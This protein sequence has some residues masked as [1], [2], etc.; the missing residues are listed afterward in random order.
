MFLVAFYGF[1]RVGELTVKGANLKSLVHVQDLHFQFSNNVVTSATVVIKDFKHN[2][3]RRPFSVFLERA[4]GFAQW[5]IYNAISLQGVQPQVPCFALLTDLQLRLTSLRSSC[6]KP[7]IFV[8]LMQLN[9]NLTL[10]GSAPPLLQLKKAYRMLKFVTL[11]V[12]NP[13]HL[14]YT[15]VNLQEYLRIKLA[16]QSWAGAT[17]ISRFCLFFIYLFLFYFIF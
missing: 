9:T 6:N 4:E 11:A 1:F 14:N 5:L 8:A 12:G 2:N 17:H 10:S 3:T 15:F 7:W 16:F 13:T